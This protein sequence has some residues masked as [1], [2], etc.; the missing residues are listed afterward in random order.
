MPIAIGNF[1]RS[2][3]T[4][5]SQ[6]RVNAINDEWVDKLAILLDRAIPLGDRFGIGLDSIIGLIPGVGDLAGGMLSSLIIFQAHRAGVP[7]PTLLRMVANVGID[8]ALGAIP[9][10]GDLFDVVWQSNLKNIKLYREA[11]Q[12]HR[13]TDKDWGFLA[14]MLLIVAV[15]TA[16]PVAIVI[17]AMMKAGWF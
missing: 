2:Q 14:L 10:V 3:R 8:T 13:R 11:M 6:G 7:R 1:A 17:W 12:G 9:F 5:Y 4:E 15:I 16:I